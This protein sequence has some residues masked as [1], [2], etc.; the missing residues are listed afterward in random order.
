MHVTI[1]YSKQPVDWLKIGSDDFGYGSDKDGKLIIK[2]GG[3][4]VM[5]KFGKAI[6][7]GFSSSDLTYRHM[8]AM[9]KCEPDGIEWK[10]DDYT[11]HITITYQG[12]DFD[13]M[14]L[15]AYQGEIEL[16]PE[17]FEEIDS[18]FDNEVHS[19]ES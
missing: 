4:R 16:G 5:E 14:H 1:L 12:A 11:P 17:I 15:A 19:T 10:H 18:G 8:S 7:L 6:V 13:I 2:A 3:P 9:N